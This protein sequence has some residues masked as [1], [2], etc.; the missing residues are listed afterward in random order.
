M[1][2]E[3]SP[4]SALES[5]PLELKWEILRV[6]PDFTS[7]LHLIRAAPVFYRA[8]QLSKDA[9]A[10]ETLS[11]GMT[12]KVLREVFTCHEMTRLRCR[13]SGEVE[14]FGD[15]FFHCGHPKSLVE[16]VSR[17]LHRLHQMVEYFAEDFR[18]KV[19]PKPDAIRIQ[20]NLYLFQFYC[21]L[22]RGRVS[23]LDLEPIDFAEMSRGFTSPLSRSKAE[24]F[25]QIYSYLYMRVSDLLR[26]C[27]ALDHRVGI[28]SKGKHIFHSLP[29]P[30]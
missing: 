16:P 18:S 6:L 2:N 11:A 1:D 14:F 5:L 24:E 21:G 13:R 27:A 17:E 22:V 8:Y 10:F 28:M 9:I 19:N 15:R 7:L 12:P 25:D 30:F 26:E 3:Q 20:R 29:P 23:A 4:L